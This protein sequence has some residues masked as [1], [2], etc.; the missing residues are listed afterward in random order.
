MMKITTLDSLRFPPLP[1]FVSEFH[2]MEL[3]EHED[4]Q[5]EKELKQIEAKVH[6]ENDN[7]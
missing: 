4:V 5:S 6:N 7:T 2:L 1:P 3:S